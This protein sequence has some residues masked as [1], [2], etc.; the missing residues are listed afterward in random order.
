L[1][2]DLE[3]NNEDKF[4]IRIKLA[5]DNLM[6]ERIQKILA[7]VGYG[8][9]RSC[10]KII[11]SGR[12]T[13]NGKGAQLGAKAD[14]HVDDIRVDGRPIANPPENSYI[15]LYKPRGVLSTVNSE[16]DSRQT[17]IDMVQ[18]PERVY[19][20]G[21]LDV[22]S[23]GLILLTNDGELTNR[24]THPR[25]EHEKQ[26]RVLIAKK[27]DE[28]QLEAWRRGIILSDGYHSAPAVVEALSTH[29]K[30]VW[31]NIV[32]R[33]GRK[34]Q[35]R[36]TGSLLGLPVVKIIRTRIGSLRLGYL[37]PRQWRKLS[38]QEIRDLRK[39]AFAKPQ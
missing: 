11:S 18:I 34:R 23:E 3:L 7:R 26:Y 19:P 29:G 1:F 8:S 6:E 10:E 14:P 33:E 15:A 17:V 22:D 4:P 38:K 32:M 21:R 25:Y 36:E 39:Y 5:V 31:L 37:K 20:V 12:V 13:V 35:I 30:G 24:L 2:P 28:K 16:K 27:P 9:R